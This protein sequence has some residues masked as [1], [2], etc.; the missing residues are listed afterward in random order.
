MATPTKTQVIGNPMML[1]RVD[2]DPRVIAARQAKEA[3]Y[4]SEVGRQVSKV[5]TYQALEALPADVKTMMDA[6][7]FN[8]HRTRLQVR[9][10]LVEAMRKEESK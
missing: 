3:F 6:V 7:Q 4:A 2:N 8:Y 10:E 1:L 9:N 5:M